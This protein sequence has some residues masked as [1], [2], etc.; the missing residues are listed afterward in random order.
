MK[1]E[2]Q[3]LKKLVFTFSVLLLLLIIS[4]LTNPTKEDYI[5]FDEAETGI[6]IPENVR[7]AEA[8]FF[9]F[10]VFAP[11]PKNTIDEYGIIHLGFMGHF[12][13]V[14]NGQFDDSIWDDVLN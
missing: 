13:K 10:S 9:F 11:A 12:F 8:N 5:K 1:K 14:T 2:P 7:I 4:A 3:R 6:P